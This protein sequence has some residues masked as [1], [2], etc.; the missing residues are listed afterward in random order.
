MLSIRHLHP[1]HPMTPQ[2][3]HQTPCYYL[4]TTQMHSIQHSPLFN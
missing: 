1:L 4:A 2:L 3:K